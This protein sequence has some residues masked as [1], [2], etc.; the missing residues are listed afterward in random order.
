MSQHLTISLP[1]TISRRLTIRQG[2][3]I[4]QYFKT[5][6]QI[7]VD[8][9]TTLYLTTLKN[10]ITLENISILDNLTTHDNQIFSKFRNFE[11]IVMF[12]FLIFRLQPQKKNL[13]TLF[14]STFDIHEKI[15]SQNRNANFVWLPL[16]NC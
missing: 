16:C 10:L 11:V 15:Y 8:N 13:T 6:Q 2:Q 4:K 14:L 5:S 7:I 9:L 12:F 1:L 3:A